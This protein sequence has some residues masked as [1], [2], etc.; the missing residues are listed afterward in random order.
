MFLVG[1]IGGI[2]LFI[3]VKLNMKLGKIQILIIDCIKGMGGMFSLDNGTGR[4]FL[5]RSEICVHRKFI[6]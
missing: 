3:L 1:E 4:R 5:T 2:F 6:Q